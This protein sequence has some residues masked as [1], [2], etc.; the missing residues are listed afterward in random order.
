M[1]FEGV[2]INGIRNGKCKEFYNNGNLKFEG[3]YLEGERNGNGKEY[4]YNG[5]L[6]FEG[7]YLKGNKW[8]GI[9]YDFD[10]KN[11]MK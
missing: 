2:Y 1:I 6:E 10:G 3:V 11:L 8:N 9:G 5:K 7:N 4:H